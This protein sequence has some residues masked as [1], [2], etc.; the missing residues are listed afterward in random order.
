MKVRDLLNRC[1]R[2][3]APTSTDSN[4]KQERQHVYLLS[5][6]RSPWYTPARSSY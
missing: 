2:H 3:E 5:P 6:F 4:A 1:V